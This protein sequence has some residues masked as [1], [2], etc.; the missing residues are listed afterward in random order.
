VTPPITL[1]PVGKDSVKV[2]PVAADSLI[3]TVAVPEVQADDLTLTKLKPAAETRH[4]PFTVVLMETVPEL[5]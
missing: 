3:T 1:A 2:L 5:G 4:K